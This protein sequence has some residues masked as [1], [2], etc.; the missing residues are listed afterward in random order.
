MKK[1]LVRVLQVRQLLEEL[2]GLDLQAKSA[3]L[4][5][6]EGRAAEHRRL[7]A[8]ARSEAIGRLLDEGATDSWLDMAD[9][10]IFLWKS[11][12]MAAAAQKA[13][14][15][16]A[17]SSERRMT[18]RMERQQAEFLIAETAHAEAQE[19]SRRE[20]QHV[21]DWFQSLP[22]SESRRSG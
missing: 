15:D 14:E 20:Q 22:S 16:V 19:R 7:A 17:V 18:R 8:E 11:E 9:A 6:L 3:R 10:E 2:A 21:D 1:G 12:R 4:R 5:Q 13:S